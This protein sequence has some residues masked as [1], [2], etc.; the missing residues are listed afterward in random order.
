YAPIADEFGL[1]S[2]GQAAGRRVQPVGS[3]QQVEPARRRLLERDIYAG[4]VLA[5]RSH[6][7]VEAELGR[8]PARLVQ[9]RREVG[10]RQLH[11]PAAGGPLE[12][13]RVDPADLT[14]GAVDEAHRSYG[15]AGP[16]E[17]GHSPPPPRQP[18]RA[19][20]AGWAEPVPPQPVRHR[21]PSDTG[22]RDQDCR[23]GPGV[24]HT[25]LPIKVDSRPDCMTN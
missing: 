5:E 22:S 10:A 1:G 15:G 8:I 11:L 20:H 18:P 16:A 23:V 12:R 19:F 2:E 6:G 7:V 21:G 9:D 3:D 14:A 13:P 25:L 24:H 17:A 4:A